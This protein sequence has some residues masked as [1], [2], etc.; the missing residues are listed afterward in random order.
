MASTNEDTPL[1]LT[2]TPDNPSNTSISNAA[3]GALFYRVVTEL[4][5]TTAV[6]TVSSAA[7]ETIAS[8]KWR[9][10]RSNIDECWLKKSLIPFNDTT[11]FSSPTNGK[12]F[13]W[14]GRTLFSKDDKTHPI[15]TFS[16]TQRIPRSRLTPEE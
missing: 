1:T 5:S 10:T 8:W 14:K 6:T 12:E 15:A 2:L 13:Q 7:G 3:D 16:P 9:D 11:T 4:E